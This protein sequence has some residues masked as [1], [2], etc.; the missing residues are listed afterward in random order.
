MSSPSRGKNGKQKGNCW[1]CR[2]GGGPGIVKKERG[3]CVGKGGEV[4]LNQKSRDVRKKGRVRT[5]KKRKFFG[6]MRKKK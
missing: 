2:R 1:N 5:K 4:D 6:L 3:E